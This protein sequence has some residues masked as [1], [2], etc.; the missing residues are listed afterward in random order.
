MVVLLTG[1]GEVYRQAK[2]LARHQALVTMEIWPFFA[3]GGVCLWKRALGRSGDE[4]YLLRRR[5][6]YPHRILTENK[7]STAC[8]G[9]RCVGKGS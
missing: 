9:L 2:L 5:L 3:N 6:A 4:G 8:C 1:L 7:Y